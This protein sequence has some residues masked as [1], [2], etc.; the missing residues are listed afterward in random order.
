MIRLVLNPEG[1]KNQNVILW[2]ASTGAIND[3]NEIECNQ[4]SVLNYVVVEFHL[5]SDYRNLRWL[6]A[7]NLPQS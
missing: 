1:V 5:K 3:A 6:K 2:M 4:R 7:E